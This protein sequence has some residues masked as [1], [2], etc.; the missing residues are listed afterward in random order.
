MSWLGRL[1][2]FDALVLTSLLWFLAKF[3]R[4]VFP[5]LFGPL[6]ST[7]GVSRSALGLAFTGFMLVYALM[8]F[9]SGLFAD[10]YGS[11]KVITGGALLASIGAI[12]LVVDTPFVLLVGGMVLMGA[13]T[14]AHKTVS[15]RLLS[16][17]YSGR[18][19]RALGIF[20]TTG[21]FG[22]AAAPIAVVIAVAGPPILGESWRTLFLAGG[23]VGIGLTISFFA[24]VP[25]RLSNTGGSESSGDDASEVSLEQ[26]ISL[27]ARPRFSGFV[28]VTIL[29]SVAY[30]GA[31][32]FLPLYLTDEIGLAPETANLLFSLL[33]LVSL[34]QLLTG[35]A[36]D[37][38]G[39]L[40][41]L[42]LTI[43]LAT[44]G[45]LVTIL[46]ADLTSP[47]VLTGAVVCLGIGAHGFRPVRGVY[48]TS[49]V[50]DTLAGGGFGVVRTLFMAA[51]SVSPAII[52]YISE[53]VGF[54]PAFG[55]LV[56]ALLC[57]T[58]I[59]VALW[60]LDR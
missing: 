57:A 37:H 54:R 18:T 32:A 4:Y 13:G 48:L 19:G 49:I 20:D 60:L 36:S 24:S 52:G 51:G 21:T 58:G 22:G 2:Q 9:P 10:R 16:R 12:I 43:G 14:G 15:V 59:S 56:A 39:A 34:V 6:Q 5:P 46:P 30:N 40:P 25:R 33:F 31:V 27:F 44:V 42:A 53:T 3:L 11:V 23:I 26:Y 17:V 45:L 1:E 8:Q 7:Y 47:I 38:V 55:L 28:A 35:E 29:F 41:V 50:P